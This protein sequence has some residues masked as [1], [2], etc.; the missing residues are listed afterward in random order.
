MKARKRRIQAL[1]DDGGWQWHPVHFIDIKVFSGLAA[2]P[3]SATVG[4][5]LGR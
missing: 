2:P 4:A 3:V 1:P 5:T